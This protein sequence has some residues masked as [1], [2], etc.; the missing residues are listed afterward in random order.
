MDR[1]SAAKY[2]GND[3]GAVQPG[4]HVLAVAD[5]A[6]NEG[7]VIDRIERRQE[8]VTG[9]CADLGFNRKL[10]GALDQLVARLPIRNQFC[11]RDALQL[12]ALGEG[13]QLRTAHH[14]AVVVHQLGKYADQRQPGE[15]AEIDTTSAAQPSLRDGRDR[16]STRLNS[17]HPSISYAVFC[18][19]KKKKK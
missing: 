1:F 8:S 10:A 6:V 12:L 13:S 16:K 15:P 5:A 14:R 3:I 17:S 18:L 19:K 4:K 11:D 9:Q 7:H 2:V